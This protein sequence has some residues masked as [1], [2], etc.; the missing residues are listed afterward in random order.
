MEYKQGYIT[1]RPMDY[2]AD[3]FY[4]PVSETKKIM[5]LDLVDLSPDQAKTILEIVKDHL[6]NLT[7]HNSIYIQERMP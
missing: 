7:E 4:K 3:V 1:E 6:E 5:F 2:I